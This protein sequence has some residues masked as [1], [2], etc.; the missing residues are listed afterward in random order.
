MVSFVY[1]SVNII[2]I[3]LLLL[4]L[5]LATILKSFYQNREEEVSRETLKKVITKRQFV[6]ENIGSEGGDLENDIYINS[7]VSSDDFDDQMSPVFRAPHRAH[8][9]LD[10]ESNVKKVSEEVKEASFFEGDSKFGL[11]SEAVKSKV[12]KKE[13]KAQEKMENI[14]KKFIKKAMI[15]IEEAENISKM[16]EDFLNLQQIYFV[17]I[18][19]EWKTKKAQSGSKMNT[20]FNENDDD[21]DFKA[22]DKCLVILNIRSWWKKIVFYLVYSWLINLVEHILIIANCV[23]LLQLDI[24]TSRAKQEVTMV[25]NLILIFLLIFISSFKLV[26]IKTAG[27]SIKSEYLLFVDIMIGLGAITEFF[28][29]YLVE[30]KFQP[31][32]VLILMMMRFFIKIY[33]ISVST[34]FKEL[35]LHMGRTM[36]EIVYFILI[37]LIIIFLFIFIGITIFGSEVP[38]DNKNKYNRYLRQANFNSFWRSFYS[39]FSFLTMEN[40]SR[41]YYE[42]RNNFG[43]EVAS[44]YF[45]LLIF[46]V[47]IV[48]F[49]FL[50]SLIINNFI[51]SSEKMEKMSKYRQASATQDVTT[52]DQIYS[53]NQSNN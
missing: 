26:L 23:M 14:K 5:I 47:S 42:Y 40:W 53:R 27:K 28:V 38:Q 41:T 31:A 50:L 45:I 7:V 19:K 21:F 44:P 20:E 46:L 36:I 37:L 9:P 39:V 25:M 4:H 32:S 52:D 12:K 29:G 34:S 51:E 11:I 49:K 35:L 10:I 24:Y 16:R 30:G 22:F 6:Y 15:D 33:C 13:D 8:R 1:F 2:V 3:N 18:I 48:M 17:K 43:G